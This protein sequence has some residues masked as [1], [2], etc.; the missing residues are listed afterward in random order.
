[1]TDSLE[2]QIVGEPVTVMLCGKERRLQYRFAAVIAYQEQTGDSLFDFEKVKKID[3]QIDPKRW[4][5]CL[6]AG[7]HEELPDPVRQGKT[8]WAPPFTVA[9]LSGLI[10]FDAQ[11]VGEIS[12]AMVTALAAHMPRAKPDP[13][14]AAP[15]EPAPAPSV[16]T[17]PS[18]GLELVVD[19]PLP[20]VNS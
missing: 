2:K 7:L 3:A 8:I 19:L 15:G 9:E 17:S 20:A 4:L 16:P 10:E 5:A 12:R 11:Q 1:M 14:A 13:K 18:S 6:W